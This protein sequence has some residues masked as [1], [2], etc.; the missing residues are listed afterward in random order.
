MYQRSADF[1]L[2]VPFN[3]ASYALLTHMIAKVCKLSVGDLIISFG[4]AHIYENQVAGVKEQ[5]KRT[6]G[7]IPR[8][9]LNPDIWDIDKFT[10]DDISLEDYDPQPAIDFPFAV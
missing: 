8:L 10:M 9:L 4:D 5:L 2:G 3:I 7:E 1:P 6:P